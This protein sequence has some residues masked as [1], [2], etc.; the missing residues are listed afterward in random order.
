ML[1]PCLASAAVCSKVKNEGAVTTGSDGFG[2]SF[3][4]DSFS[5]DPREVA[6]FFIRFN[7]DFFVGSV[8]V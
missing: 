5:V 8:S 2:T 7:S 6:V 4:T 1:M 3:E